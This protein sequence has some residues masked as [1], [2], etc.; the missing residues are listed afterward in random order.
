MVN[1]WSR[2]LGP[3]CT[4]ALQRWQSCTSVSSLTACLFCNRPVY[5]PICPCICR[6]RQ[7]TDAAQEN[8]CNARRD[9]YSPLSPTDVHPGST[10]GPTESEN[11]DMF[12]RRLVI[13]S[14]LIAGAVQLQVAASESVIR[15]SVNEKKIRSDMSS[16]A[17]QLR[18]DYN[19][20]FFGHRQSQYQV[21]VSTGINWWIFCSI[22]SYTKLDELYLYL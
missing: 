6:R 20:Q 19:Y 5:W 13:A 2:F 14:A 10:V 11:Y 16:A 22:K 15:E 9:Q 21:F 18:A 12:V 17:A 1:L 7:V 4:A 8:K 3:P